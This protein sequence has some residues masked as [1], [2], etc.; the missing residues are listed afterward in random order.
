ML[1]P[2][3]ELVSPGLVTAA[4]WSADGRYVL[5]NRSLMRLA[6]PVTQPPHMEA[7]LVL[8][9]Q[10]TRRAQEVWKSKNA[11]DGAAQIA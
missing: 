1:L 3:P 11:G 5:A 10:G 7:S 6:S 9:S 4:E 2:V 8:W